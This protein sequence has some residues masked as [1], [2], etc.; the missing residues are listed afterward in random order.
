MRI[1]SHFVNIK[2]S[3]FPTL[4]EGLDKPIDLIREEI[5]GSDLRSPK[6]LK[7]VR[8][9]KHT[10]AFLNDLL[11]LMQTYQGRI[12]GRV[13]VK[14]PDEQTNAI[15]IY[16]SGLQHI[17]TEF[18]HFLEE[19]NSTG[20]VICDSRNHQLDVQASH[21]IF[22][23]KHQRKGD[24]Y[25]KILEMPL[26][27]KSDNHSGIQLSDIICSAFLFPFAS[28]TFCIEHSETLKNI[29]VQPTHEKLRKT[30]S[31]RVASLQYRRTTFRNGKTC[32]TGGVF[33]SNGLDKKPAHLLFSQPTSIESKLKDL[34]KK[35]SKPANHK[36][37]LKVVKGKPVIKR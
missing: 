4:A 6:A 17:C 34:E 10:E 28:H 21:S 2:K 31:R 3:Y 32:K 18:N 22:T 35:H 33:L 25:P 5:K 27:G 12:I 11:N 23:Q 1:T 9:W 37:R 7:N 16:T 24:S 15:G 8:K 36:K 30:F 14:C 26:F 19:K 20:I 13:I 29:H